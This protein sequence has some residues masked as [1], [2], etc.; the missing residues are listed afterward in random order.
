LTAN[1]ELNLTVEVAEKDDELITYLPYKI[2]LADCTG[3]I[4]EVFVMA[5]ADMRS[6]FRHWFF[7]WNI[8]ER[9]FNGKKGSIDTALI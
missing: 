4:Q 1:I 5:K 6:R 9:L 8:R 7:R 2:C 3:S